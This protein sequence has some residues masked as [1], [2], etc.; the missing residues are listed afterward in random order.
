MR[1]RLRDILRLLLP[2]RL[3]GRL[4]VREAH[5]YEEH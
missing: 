5:R 2:A 3:A 4:I 1:P